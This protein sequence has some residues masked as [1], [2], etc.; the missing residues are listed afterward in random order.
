MNRLPASIARR[1]ASLALLAAISMALGASS[2]LAEA[3]PTDWEPLFQGIA[4]ATAQTDTPRLQ[5]INALRVD[6]AEPNLR[7]I[8][9]PSNGD[10]PG[11]TTRR[12]AEQFLD[13]FEVQ[14]VVNTHFYATTAAI[15]WKAD[16]IGL[17]VTEGER[18]SDL[19]DLPHG[20]VSLL[21]T[22]DNAARFER[23]TPDSDLTG[24]WTA[25][26]SWPYFLVNGQNHGDP[27]TESIH[28]RTAVGLS[29][30]ERY[31]IFITIDGRQPGYSEGAT[32]EE[33]A[34]W[35]LEFGAHHGLNLDGGGSTHMWIHDPEA[36]PRALN[37]PSENRAVGSQLGIYAA[38][39]DG[40][41][42]GTDP[43]E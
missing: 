36:G 30:D 4:H 21:L 9:T 2:A 11:D 13:E 1:A 31:L 19:E 24:V 37:Q 43:A 35:L 3:T 27:T 7:F 14:V 28:P 33:T 12:T 41:D 25:V 20:G 29:E 10:A 17:S 16:L 22:K 23:T 42:T 39:L 26:E 34:Q 38:P 15:D 6:L 32:F 40:A 5:V 8:A 18:V